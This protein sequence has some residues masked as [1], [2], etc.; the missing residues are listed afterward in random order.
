[1]IRQLRVI[2]FSLLALALAACATAPES[3]TQYS[4]REYQEG[5]RKEAFYRF[6][7]ECK[8]ARGRIRIEGIGSS[9]LQQ[10][11]GQMPVPGVGEKYWCET[12]SM[13][14]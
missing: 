11:D 1:M 14:G 5:L 3:P 7:D 12:P 9:D 13:G 6:I 10:A 8:A 2:F 4:E